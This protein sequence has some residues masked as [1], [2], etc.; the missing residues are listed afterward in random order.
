VRRE[1]R[2]LRLPQDVERRAKHNERADRGQDGHD[3]TR[4]HGDKPSSRGPDI[5]RA[6]RLALLL[7]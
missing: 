2:E 6:E 3:P 7:P 1:V 5:A 4:D